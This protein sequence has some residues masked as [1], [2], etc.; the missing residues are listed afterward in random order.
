[1]TLVVLFIHMLLLL[2]FKDTVHIKMSSE[3]LLCAAGVLTEDALGNKKPAISE[4]EQTGSAKLLTHFRVLEVTPAA[5]YRHLLARSKD[6][7][8]SNMF[9]HNILFF[10]VVWNT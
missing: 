7:M 5:L 10:E 4:E 6:R 9:G 2:P 1:M 8:Y 3:V